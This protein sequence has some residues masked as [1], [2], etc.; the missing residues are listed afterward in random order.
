[1]P[2]GDLTPAQRA[3]LQRILLHAEEMSGLTFSVYVG[4]YDGGRERVERM[5]AEL[6]HPDRSVMVAVDPDH[7]TLEI[8]TGRLARIPIDD[9]ACGLAALSMTSSFSA[10]DL[11]GG[12]R[13]GIN[14]LADHGRRMRV[15]HV[16]Q[17]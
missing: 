9:H 11:M 2:A 17:V 13:D 14:V 10:G 1:M 8:V 4:S 15:A 3:D 16:D 6:S 7:R 5:L 12:L